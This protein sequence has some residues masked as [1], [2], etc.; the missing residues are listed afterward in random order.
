M[1]A[2]RVDEAACEDL[3]LLGFG[4]ELPDTPGVQVPDSVR[5]LDVAVNVDGLVHV[6]HAIRP[7][8]QRVQ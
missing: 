2:P 3:E 5:R 1:V 6:E 4:A 7:P 8:A